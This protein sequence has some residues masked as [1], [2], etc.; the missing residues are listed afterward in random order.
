MQPEL[1]SIYFG[2]GGDDE[3][4]DDAT[5]DIWMQ[6]IYDVTNS[7][8]SIEH[9]KMKAWSQH[10][11]SFVT[12]MSEHLQCVQI[13][14]CFTNLYH[15]VDNVLGQKNPPLCLPKICFN[16]AYR[17]RESPMQEHVQYV[18]NNRRIVT[19]GLK[20]RV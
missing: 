10:I 17:V 19:L 1:F 8:V 6:K 11:L 20:Q 4:D 18:L 5:K 13:C 12:L 15:E 7:E 3:D 2:D 9:L 14:I 16:D